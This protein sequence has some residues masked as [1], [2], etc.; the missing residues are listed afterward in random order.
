MSYEF[1]TKTMSVEESKMSVEERLEESQ[2]VEERLEEPIYVDMEERLEES[3]IVEERLEEPIY[4]DKVKPDPF[5]YITKVKPNPFYYGAFFSHLPLELIKVLLTLVISNENIAIFWEFLNS[6]S[7]KG[8]PEEAEMLRE[9]LYNKTIMLYGR[10]RKLIIPLSMLSF[11]NLTV[12]SFYIRAHPKGFFFSVRLESLRKYVEPQFMSNIWTL[13]GLVKAQNLIQNG[14]LFHFS[15]IDTHP[16]NIPANFE[17]DIRCQ[18][19]TCKVSSQTVIRRPNV[20]PCSCK[21]CI[22]NEYTQVKFIGIGKTSFQII[23]DNDPELE[24]ENIMLN[25]TMITTIPTIF[26]PQRCYTVK[27]EKN[28]WCLCARDSTEL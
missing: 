28:G 24:R 9:F 1:Q 25:R 4:V 6:S 23:Q 22:E 3:Q 14:A 17:H 10:N 12:S 27:C 15:L 7:F 21:K 11:N 8:L 2:I 13:L 26:I 19:K 18:C 5:Y 20:S 16:P